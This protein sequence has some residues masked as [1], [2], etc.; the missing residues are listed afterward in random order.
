MG[1]VR[2]EIQK[3]LVEFGRHVAKFALGELHA[4]GH[5]SLVFFPNMK[6]QIF[7][8]KTGELEILLTVK[9]GEGAKQL[10]GGHNPFASSLID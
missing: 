1:C 4:F 10:F 8:K 5:T 3:K 9:M 7:L 2:R 6:P